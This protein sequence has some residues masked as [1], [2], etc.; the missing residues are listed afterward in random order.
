MKTGKHAFLFVFATGV[1]GQF[2]ADEVQSQL[3]A[4]T[5]SEHSLDHIS[6]VY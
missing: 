6:E 4:A 1:L 2:T 5:A 3:I